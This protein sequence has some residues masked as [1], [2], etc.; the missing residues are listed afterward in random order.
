VLDDWEQVW[1]KSPRVDALRARTSLTISSAQVPP[2]DVQGPIGHSELGRLLHDAEI[3]VLNR[4]RTAVD[5]RLLRLAPKLEAIFNTGTGIN[6]VDRSAVAGHCITLHTTGGESWP[7]VVEQTFALM[8]GCIKRTVELDGAVRTGRFPQ[9]LLG[10]LYG[11]RLGIAGMGQIGSRVA[12]VA[13]AF[14]MSVVV[15]SRSLTHQHAQGMG[16]TPVP[17]LVELAAASD[18]LTLHLRLTPNTTGIVGA[19]VLGALRPGAVLINTARAALIDQAALS[20]RL[21]RED[22]LVGLDVFPT[23]PMPAGDRLLVR[24]GTLSPHVGWMTHGTWDRF[25]AACVERILTW[26]DEHDESAGRRHELPRKAEHAA[27]VA[28]TSTESD[29]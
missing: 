13:Q 18:V 19:D 24:P 28:Q 8:L 14:G 9:P 6:H 15:W 5:E 22:L 10:E 7:S 23:E 29:Q 3:L 2:A 12:Q 4:E 27:S 21:R 26:L 17:S 16:V 25:V 11:A 20:E 1:E